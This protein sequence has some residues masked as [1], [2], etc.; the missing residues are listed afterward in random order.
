MVGIPSPSPKPWYVRQTWP[1]VLGVILG[2]FAGASA[3]VAECV[4]SSSSGWK[5]ASQATSLFALLALGAMK[6]AESRHREAR[7]DQKDSPENLRGPLHVIHR[8]IAG[9]KQVPDPAEGWLRITI[10]RV[11]GDWLEQAV[12]YVG[13]A[14]EAQGRSAG[15]RFSINAGLIGRVARTGE[16]RR[17]SRAPAMDFPDWVTYLVGETAMKRI[18]AERTRPDR[19]GFLGV[20][21]KGSD[22]E[23]RAVLY[24]DSRDSA[25]FDEKTVAIVAHGCSGLAKWIDEHYYRSR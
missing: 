22:H 21:I 19:F 10:H 18:D 17:F 5:I 13:S 9:L 20:P 25:F 15:R 16:V 12:P 7:D 23:V 8:T 6:V 1:A 4:S 24:L 2:G 14:D 11:D 3:L